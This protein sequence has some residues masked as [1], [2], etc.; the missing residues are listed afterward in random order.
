MAGDVSSDPLVESE[1]EKGKGK[2]HSDGWGPL[3]P[4]SPWL[5]CLEGRKDE[6]QQ[7]GKCLVQDAGGG[8]SGSA[9]LCLQEM[10][11]KLGFLLQLGF[12]LQVVFPLQLVHRVQVL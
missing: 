12:H 8:E 10:L 9:P 11:P 6:K 7:H 4:A 1:D 5:T 3:G 2:G